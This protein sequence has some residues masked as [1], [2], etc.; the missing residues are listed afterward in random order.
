MHTDYICPSS[1]PVSM[2]VR[3]SRVFT[4][5]HMC[6]VCAVH[7]CMPECS[8]VGVCVVCVYIYVRMCMRRA[9]VCGVCGVYTMRRLRVCDVSVCLFVCV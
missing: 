5:E 8:R 6:V 2:S 3:A 9:Y 7:V 1:Y 4:Y